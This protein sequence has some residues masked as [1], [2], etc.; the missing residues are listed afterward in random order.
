ML[1]REH[2]AQGSMLMDEVVDNGFRS[3]NVEMPRCRQQLEPKPI[4]VQQC[5]GLGYGRTGAVLLFDGLAH[6]R[7]GSACRSSV[8]AHPLRDSNRSKQIADCL[9]VV[10]REM[11][12]RGGGGC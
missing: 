5:Q 9:H 3:G 7:G 4:V 1:V 8:V 12:L 6:Q 2:R 10:D 11:G